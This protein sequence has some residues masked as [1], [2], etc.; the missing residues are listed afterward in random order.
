MRVH[1]SLSG[2]LVI[3]AAVATGFLAPAARATD[4][5]DSCED[6]CEEKA[7]ECE[8]NAEAAAVD[9][10]RK[11]EADEEWST[12]LCGGSIDGKRSVRCETV[13]TKAAKKATKCHVKLEKALE[14]C[15]ER[16]STCADRCD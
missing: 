7:F 14:R 9:C 11:I 4:R 6:R 13:C 12:C 3:A 5:D 10:T 15:E 1:G 2:V 16:E 8:S